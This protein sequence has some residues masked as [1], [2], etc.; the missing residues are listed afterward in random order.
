MLAS[1]E[2]SSEIERQRRRQ[3]QRVDRFPPSSAGCRVEAAVGVCRPRSSEQFVERRTP[4]TPSTVLPQYVDQLVAADVTDV[5]QPMRDD[6]A[7]I[8]SANAPY[9]NNHKISKPERHICVGH[10]KSVIS[11][12]ATST[13]TPKS[14]PDVV[15]EVRSAPLKFDAFRADAGLSSSGHDSRTTGGRSRLPTRRWSSLKE[16][17]TRSPAA[18]DRRSGGDR[19]TSRLDRHVYQC[20][21]AGIL[22]SSRRS[23]R[24]VRLQQLYSVLENT[25]RI[26]TEMLSARQQ[27]TTP[28]LTDPDSSDAT[29]PSDRKHQHQ[30]SLELRKLYAKLDAAQD[31]REFFYDNG[32]LDAFQWKS[33]RDLGLSKKSS[34]LARLKDLFESAV[35]DSRSVK[36][37]QSQRVERGLSY[38]KLLGTF[39]RLEKRTRK[40]A[41]AWL[42]WQSSSQQS[43]TGGRK[44]DGTYIQMMEGAAKNAKALALHGYHMHE[45][46]NRYDAYVQSRRIYRPKSAP[47]IFEQP[48]S[49]EQEELAS[50]SDRTTSTTS[51][52]DNS[53][54]GNERNDEPTAKPASTDS[55]QI[56]SPVISVSSVPKSS[57]SA[58]HANVCA[59]AMRAPEKQSRQ[60]I[61][62]VEIAA[63]GKQSLQEG[64]NSDETLAKQQVTADDDPGTVVD[65]LDR[66]AVKLGT[67]SKQ[68]TRKRERQRP[69]YR[70]GNGTMEKRTDTLSIPDCAA[71]RHIEAWRRSSRPLS[72]TLN[73]ALAYFNSLC[74]ENSNDKNGQPVLGESGCNSA[75]SE[76]ENR[77]TLE[78]IKSGEIS[79]QLTPVSSTMTENEKLPVH[80]LDTKFSN[81]SVAVPDRRKVVLPQLYSCR[82]EFLEAEFPKSSVS[83]RPL[84]L[85]SRAVNID[86]RCSQY[87]VGTMEPSS[88]GRGYLGAN[89]KETE[90]ETAG[91]RSPITSHSDVTTTPEVHPTYVR[92]APVVRMLSESQTTSVPS[93]MF[94]ECRTADV[95]KLPTLVDPNCRSSA[96]ERPPTHNE[97]IMSSASNLAACTDTTSSEQLLDADWPSP[98]DEAKQ[99]DNKSRCLKS[100]VSKVAATSAVSAT[101]RSSSDAASRAKTNVTYVTTV[102]SSSFICRRC[103]RS[104]PACSCAS[105]TA[106]PGARCGGDHGD[107]RQSNDAGKS[108]SPKSADKLT[109]TGS[110]SAGDGH[111]QPLTG[112]ADRSYRRQTPVA[113]DRPGLGLQDVEMRRMMA[114]LETIDSEWTSSCRPM[115]S[116]QP[117]HLAS[118]MNNNRSPSRQRTS[119]DI[120][121]ERQLTPGHL[122][123]KT[124][125]RRRR[126]ETVLSRR[127]CKHNSQ[128]AHD[129]GRQIRSTI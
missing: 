6:S 65:E 99:T 91:V 114:S 5:R 63:V 75:L 1:T 76:N 27:R 16:L 72:G 118:D 82:D 23:E 115:R 64:V 121:D 66:A 95:R 124:H 117:G 78:Q 97:R 88:P 43:M 112:T 61:F 35:V 4:K 17:S 84:P 111:W 31:D 62:S 68:K 103:C 3:L 122:M 41:E 57:A 80:Q 2:R 54:H 38:A 56:S 21:F 18:A 58:Q 20:Y 109:L 108:Q 32:R 11:D 94:V 8:A 104:L 123:P 12:T 96:A 40:E 79:N 46:R 101:R 90:A 87:E 26:E 55:S 13:N 113:G 106:E 128:L 14:V 116:T 45:H 39:R 74:I 100:E 48:S 34:S 10:D 69:R 42:R 105:S 125:R 36:T 70:R 60:P 29:D 92:P 49:D 129:D 73:Q 120:N 89:A 71:R 47:N 25:V 67:R 19:R 59:E 102:D 33:W 24:F 127:R 15:A 50:C 37:S 126:D 7:N 9:S 30:R 81:E 44:L 85:C 83:G 119:D 77:V 28:S 93:P 107:R 51:F 52:C 22:H 98:D 53:R 86:K 110:R